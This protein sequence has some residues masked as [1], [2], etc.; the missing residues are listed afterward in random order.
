MPLHFAVI[1]GHLEIVHF[2]IE[3]GADVNKK[4]CWGWTPLHVAT[5]HNQIKA[6]KIL[7]QHGANL[8][9]ESNEGRTPL[10]CLSSELRAKFLRYGNNQSWE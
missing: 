2:L 3:H 8:Y 5:A 10:D 4:S 7:M 1:G 9:T 6:A